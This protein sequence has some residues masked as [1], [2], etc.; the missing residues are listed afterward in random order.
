ME[1]N[2]DF[3]KFRQDLQERR[4]TLL[5]R[6]GRET[7]PEGAPTVTNPDKSDLAQDYVRRDRDTA[8]I[9]QMEDTLREIETALQKLDEGTY[10]RCARCGKPI[11]PERL[12]ALPYAELCIECQELLE[13]R[14]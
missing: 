5:A 7:E 9:E 11:A 4:A 13:R 3:N 1:N 2:I 10:G 12:E 14:Y 8:L 6:L